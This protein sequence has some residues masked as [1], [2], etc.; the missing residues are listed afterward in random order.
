ML[1][2]KRTTPSPRQDLPPK[3]RKSMKKEAKKQLIVILI[4]TV[5]LLGFYYGTLAF[6]PQLNFVVM[7]AYMIIFGVALVAY[8]IYNRGFVNK[9]V[10]ED[11]LPENWSDE[12]KK[13][14][15]A[16]EIRRAEKSRWMLV[17]IVPFA[18]VFMAEALY[19]YVW[20]GWLG[21]FF[22]NV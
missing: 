4:M 6:S 2:P 3:E 17:I 14:F 18:A 13:S 7:I 15:L 19:H 9:G 10:T 11:M 8:I 22:K 20:N 1:F 16:G 5:F 12:K 21:N